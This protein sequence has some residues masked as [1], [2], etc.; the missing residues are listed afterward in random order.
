MKKIY[1]VYSDLC[2]E[3]D[4]FFD[5]KFKL[6]TYWHSNDASWRPEYMGSLLKALGAEVI[7]LDYH[8]KRVFKRVKQIH[9]DGGCSEEE[10]DETL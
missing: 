9:L 3:Y 6:I 4:I 1:Y 2:G 10:L 5:A 7:D 8:D